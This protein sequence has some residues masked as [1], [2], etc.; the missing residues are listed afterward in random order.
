M[1]Q[2]IIRTPSSDRSGGSNHE[3]VSNESKKLQSPPPLS[4]VTPSSRPFPPRYRNQS[5]VETRGPLVSGRPIPPPVPETLDEEM[6]E[7]DHVFCYYDP[8]PAVRESTHRVELFSNGIVSDEAP[9]V[10]RTW[11]HNPYA[12]VVMILPGNTSATHNN[13]NPCSIRS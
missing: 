13:S 5:V 1:P 2:L 7:D 11:R 12:V 4:V 6:L 10:V 8:A 3:T 9:H